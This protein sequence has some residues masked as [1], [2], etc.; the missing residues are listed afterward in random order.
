M[1][2]EY[3]GTSTDEVRGWARLNRERMNFSILF[4]LTMDSDY[5]IHREKWKPEIKRIHEDLRRSLPGLIRADLPVSRKILM[6]GF[7]YDTMRWWTSLGANRSAGF[8]TMG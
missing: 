8:F 1:V 6:I 2:C 7:S 4:L 5:K 3:A